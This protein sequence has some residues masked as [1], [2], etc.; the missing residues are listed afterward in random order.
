[1]KTTV[2]KNKALP[3]LGELVMCTVVQVNPTH[4]YLLLD[5]YKGERQGR[6]TETLDRSKLNVPDSIKYNAIAYMHISEVANHWIKNI[7]EFVR[8]GQKEVCKVLKMDPKKGQIDLSKRR[9]SQQEKRE[10]LKQWKRSNKAEGLLHLLA[11][12]LQVPLEDL[13]QKIAFPLDDAYG[14]DLWAAFEDIKEQGIQSI[15]DL[16]FAKEVPEEWLKEL[17]SLIQDSVSIPSVHIIGEFELSSYAPNGV[18]VIKEAITAGQSVLSE[19]DDEETY[20]LS[21]QT[22]APPRY[23]MEIEAPDYQT[24]EVFLEKIESKVLKTVKKSGGNGTFK[25]TS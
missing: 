3:D 14:D 19:M 21:I 12:R 24:A 9:V 10:K 20:K 5:D 18:E 17:E 16:P 11:E 13:F 15:M 8:E 2:R 23:R 25:R 7:R 22:I 4:V 6:E 1:V